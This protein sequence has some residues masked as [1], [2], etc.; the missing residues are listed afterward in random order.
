ISSTAGRKVSEVSRSSV[1]MLRLQVW[2]PPAVGVLV[3]AGRPASAPQAGSAASASARAGAIRSTRS[4]A[5]AFLHELLQPVRE[6]GPAGAGG[7]G[8]RLELQARHL[9]QRVDAVG[10]DAHHE[11]RGADLDQHYALALPDGGTGDDAQRAAGARLSRRQ[12]FH[13]PRR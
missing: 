10:G 2:P 5:T 11:P 8:L 6:S 9:V 12:A 13:E 7:R 4:A 3:N 1:W